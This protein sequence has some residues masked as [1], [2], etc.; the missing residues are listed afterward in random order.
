MTST[1]R[2][3][4]GTIGAGIATVSVVV[5]LQHRPPLTVTSTAALE[6]PRPAPLNDSRTAA[7]FA[8][9]V[10]A[11]KC[12]EPD[13]GLN[14]LHASARMYAAHAPLR[15]PEVADPD[16]PAN[17]GILQAMVAKAIKHANAKAGQ[18]PQQTTH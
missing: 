17:R 5:W 11:A 6:A 18:Q 3:W 9:A 13:H 8:P 12:V 16:S 2:K 4:L 14:E 15:A 7:A 10:A 1:K